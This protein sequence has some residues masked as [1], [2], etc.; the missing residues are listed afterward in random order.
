MELILIADE[1]S[2]LLNVVIGAPK[3]VAGLF[4]AHLGEIPLRGD[5]QDVFERVREVIRRN[6]HVLGHVGDFDLE[7]VIVLDEF[8][9]EHDEHFLRRG[10]FLFTAKLIHQSGEQF[11]HHPQ[12][13]QI[14]LPFFGIFEVNGIEIFPQ[15]RVIARND[16]IF[17]GKVDAL[18][19]LAD[20][21]PVEADPFV[22]PRI[23]GVGVIFRGYAIGNKENGVFRQFVPDSI[24]F[25]IPFASQNIV[26]QMVGLGGVDDFL[27]DPAFFFS[28]LKKA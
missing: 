27:V 21:R 2:D 3:Q 22:D 23:V 9:G 1:Q 24:Q 25:K 7:L 4:H 6:V 17:G 20:D 10:V 26:K 19:N 12:A 11:V 28:A 14:K 18:E 5:V 13:L 15:V 8:L 16:R